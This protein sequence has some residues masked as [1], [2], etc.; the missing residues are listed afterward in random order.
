M[1]VKKAEEYIAHC[2][3]YFCD[4]QNARHVFILSENFSISS[5]VDKRES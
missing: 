4:N 3:I 2:Y 1:H 5:V